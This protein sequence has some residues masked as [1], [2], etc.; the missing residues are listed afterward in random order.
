MTHDWPAQFVGAPYREGGD[1][2]M[3]G[4]DC[5]GLV[6]HVGQRV[7]AWPAACFII[8]AA[9]RRSV[10]EDVCA[11]TREAHA[12]RARLFLAGA[13]D[14]AW[15]AV[16]RPSGSPAI[17]LMSLAGRP[18]HCGVYTG[19]GRVLHCARGV[20]TVHERIDAVS[21]GFKIE[22]YHVPS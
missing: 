10:R 8:G 5:W 12:A 9:V 2:P 19:R 3:R 16:A 15:R 6:A 20:D 22:S 11:D 1:D 14:E 21:L 13:G 18:I 7:L 4:W 17:V